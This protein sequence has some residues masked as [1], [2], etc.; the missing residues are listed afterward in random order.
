MAHNIPIGNNRVSLAQKYRDWIESRLLV[1]SDTYVEYYA[2]GTWYPYQKH[3]NR[4]NDKSDKLP[5]T[6]D[7][8]DG[9]ISGKAPIG[10][11]PISKDNRSKW[12]CLDIDCHWLDGETEAEHKARLETN[13][14]YIRALACALLNLGFQPMV[15]QSSADGSCKVWLFFDQTISSELAYRFGRWIVNEKVKWDEHG[16]DSEPEA[17]PKQPFVKEGQYGNVVRLPGYRPGRDFASVLFDQAGK[18]HPYPDAIEFITSFTGDSP[19]KIPG[20][21]QAF[22]PVGKSSNNQCDDLRVS[23]DLDDWRSDYSGDL[24]TLDI[25]GLFEKHGLDVW[26]RGS[27]EYEVTCPWHEQ[28]TTGSDTA[29]IKIVDGHV[30]MFNCFHNHCESRTIQDVLAWF[31]KEDIDAYCERAYDDLADLHRR[32]VEYFDT[33]ASSPRRKRA[34]RIRELFKLPPVSWQVEN[35]L[36]H[37]S[38]CCIYGKYA[39]GKSFYALDLALSSACGKP[40]LGLHQVSAMPVAYIAAEGHIGITKR[41]DAWLRFHKTEAPDDFLLLPERHN[42][43]DTTTPEQIKR[44]VCDELGKLPKLII[45]DT[46]AR[47]FCGGDEN[48]TKDMNLFVENVTRLGS[49]CDDAS[50]VVVHHVGKDE[51]KGARGSVALNGACETM[52]EISAKKEK[53]SLDTVTA[54]CEKQKDAPPFETY[55]LSVEQID[56]PYADRGS[57]VLVPANAWKTKAELLYPS[58]RATL[59]TLYSSFGVGSYT[60]NEGLKAVGLP[61]TTYWEHVDKLKRRGFVRETHDDLMVNNADAAVILTTAC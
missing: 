30:P 43:L 56:L 22:Q 31:G 36:P 19:A 42:L 21:A 32:V 11:L 15:E 27:G 18:S 49:I 5:V 6:D 33:L 58:I 47:M 9:H 26:D 51:T 1:R 20:E 14:Q 52:I 44:I 25:V 50:V 48:S 38:L 3:S 40:F 8:I 29:G 24:T 53:D 45:C 28:H 7:V 37:S 39:S 4:P 54:R 35:H 60:W 46:L 13:R 34:Y 12:V 16:L 10:L 17:F 61:K 57:L 55:S 23:D 59:D 2:G 41:I